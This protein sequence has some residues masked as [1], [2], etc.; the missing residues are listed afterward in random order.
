LLSEKKADLKT[1]LDLP[2]LVKICACTA[3][4]ENSG[5]GSEAAYASPA[6]GTGLLPP[7]SAAGIVNENK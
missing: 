4:R 1:P 5:L 7:A 6:A 3:G 2:K